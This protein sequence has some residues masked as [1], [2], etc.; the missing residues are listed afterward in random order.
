KRSSRTLARYTVEAARVLG[1]LIQ[2]GRKRR[3]MTQADLAERL[4]I[5]RSTLQ[6]VERGDPRVE[7]GIMFEAAT[8]VGVQLFDED[9]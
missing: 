1:K 6:R 2:Q 5:A 9:R 8:L 7:I 4:G 3:R